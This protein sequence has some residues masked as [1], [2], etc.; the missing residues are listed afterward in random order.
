VKKL[1]DHPTAF[2]IWPTP[3]SLPE[4]FSE[5]PINEAHRTLGIHTTPN[6]NSK[7]Q[8]E[9]LHQKCQQQTLL[10][11]INP[12]PPVATFTAYQK[13][14]MP[15]FLYP[16]VAQRL[17]NRAINKLQSPIIIQV[18]HW[19]NLSS[20]MSRRLIHLPPMFGGVGIPNWAVTTCTHQIE[21]LQSALDAQTFYGHTMHTSHLTWQLEYGHGESFIASTDVR[22]E[23]MAPTWIMNLHS[24]H[25]LC[26][27]WG[28]HSGHL[29]S[30]STTFSLQL[31]FSI[32]SPTSPRKK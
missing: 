5:K 12:L 32:T 19:L 3:T 26:G 24:S 17:P 31:S 14:L 23:G 2:S 15:A 25:I 9:L 30:A 4:Q 8:F 10:M 18:L 20:T 21:F 1:V 28:L 6:L 27:I 7:H 11:R 16:L 22:M 13:H 29:S